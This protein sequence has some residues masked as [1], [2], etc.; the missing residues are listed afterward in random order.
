MHDTQHTEGELR[1]LRDYP[2]VDAACFVTPRDGQPHFVVVS[3][4]LAQV[5]K[6][7][8]KEGFVQQPAKALGVKVV[9][10]KP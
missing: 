4:H 3:Y 6:T 2:F 1:R 8:A 10:S 9:A 5:G 7:L